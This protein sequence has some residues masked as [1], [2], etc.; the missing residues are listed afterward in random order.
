MNT[1]LTNIYGRVLTITTRK[2]VAGR[3][4]LSSGKYFSN[5]RLG[6]SHTDELTS[7]WYA[8]IRHSLT[9]DLVRELG[10]FDTK[11]EAV[12]SILWRLERI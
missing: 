2:I 7:K 8:D 4:Q 10:W 9:G 5:I 1:Q 3:Y 6:Y 11:T 12:E